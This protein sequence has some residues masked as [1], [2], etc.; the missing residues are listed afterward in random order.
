MQINPILIII[1]NYN[2]IAKIINTAVNII[3]IRMPYQ[4]NLDHSIVKSDEQG[5]F[6]D[7]S[8]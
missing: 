3:I 6:F 1:G 4:L 7:D 2:V 5:R 8:V